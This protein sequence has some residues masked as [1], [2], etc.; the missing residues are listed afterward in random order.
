M[1]SMRFD[2]ILVLLIIFFDAIKGQ[3]VSW[4]EFKRKFS[5]TYP[6]IEEENHR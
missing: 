1:K 5:K 2:Y 4:E 3:L 6:S